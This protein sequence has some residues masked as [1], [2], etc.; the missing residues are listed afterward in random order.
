MEI[1]A[2]V[3]AIQNLTKDAIQWDSL[4]LAQKIQPIVKQ[5]APVEVTDI[6]K[7]DGKVL[8]A[9]N[10]GDRVIKVTG[11]MRHLYN[12]SYK[13]TEVGEGICLTYVAAGLIETHSYDRTAQGWVYNSMDKCTIQVDQ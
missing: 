4:I 3:K 5:L 13:G 12:V 8:D 10:C 11:T 6:T 1:Q 9:L 7:I 2:L